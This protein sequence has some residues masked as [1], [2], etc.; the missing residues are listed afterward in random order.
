MEGGESVGQREDGW[1]EIEHNKYPW[2]QE[3]DLCSREQSQIMEAKTWL[4]VVVPRTRCMYVIFSFISL[5]LIS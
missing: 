5:N 1:S 3:L 2:D 4:W